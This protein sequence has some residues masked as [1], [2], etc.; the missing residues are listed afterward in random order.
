HTLTTFTWGPD[1]A[2]YW[3]T[4]TFLHSQVET[5]YGVRR[6][7]YGATWRYEP[8]THKLEPYISYPYANAWGH[9]FLRDGTEIVS[10]VSTGMNYFAPPLTVASEYPRKLLRMK[11]FLTAKH[12]PKVCGIEV[13]SSSNF[14]DEN[15][16]NMLFNTFVRSQGVNQHQI[17]QDSSGIIGAEVEPLL[18]SLNPNFRPVDLQ[19]GPDGALYVVDWYNPIINHGERALRDTLRDH[20]H[21]RIWRITYRDRPLLKPLDLTELSTMG[22]LDQLKAE[23]DRVRYRVRTL[24]RQKQ[25]DEV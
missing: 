19:F 20:T 1:G 14:P 23:E 22:L 5:P 7:D 2:L 8:E 9:V 12:K 3:H 25:G 16:G 10:D 15:Q 6:S 17:Q 4:G 18:K 11:D 13:V 24:L 21:G